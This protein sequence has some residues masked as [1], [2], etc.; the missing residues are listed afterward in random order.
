MS[1]SRISNP[2]AA[3]TVSRKSLGARS[4][5]GAQNMISSL[6]YKQVRAKS[7]ASKMSSF[8]RLNPLLPSKNAD[9]PKEKRLE[10]LISTFP[11]KLNPFLIE[12]SAN[13]LEYFDI[14][15]SLKA[16]VN[17]KKEFWKSWFEFKNKFI[18]DVENAKDDYESTRAPVKAIQTVRENF[19]KFSS[20]ISEVRNNQ[21]NKFK[22]YYA[23][24][25]KE[26]MESFNQIQKIIDVQLNRHS[27]L[28]LF[29]RD[30]QFIIIQLKTFHDQLP[31]EHDRFFAEPFDPQYTNVQ[32]SKNQIISMVL[33]PIKETISYLTMFMNPSSVID[34]ASKAIEKQEELFINIIGEPTVKA[35]DRY[36]KADSNSSQ[37]EINDF[38]EI[39]QELEEQQQNLT[40][41]LEAEIKKKEEKIEEIAKRTEEWEKEKKRLEIELKSLSTSDNSPENQAKRIKSLEKQI[42]EKEAELAKFDKS[43]MKKQYKEKEAVFEE[44][45]KEFKEIQTDIIYQRARIQAKVDNLDTEEQKEPYKHYAKL[46]KEVLSLENQLE[47][48]QIAT[49]GFRNFMK[50]FKQQNLKIQQIDNPQD[51]L[52]IEIEKNENKFQYID[53][54]IRD[55]KLLKDK[56]LQARSK[57][58]LSYAVEEFYSEQ[59]KKY[60]RT[61][62]RLKAMIKE[63]PNAEDTRPVFLAWA[64][65]LAKNADIAD[66]QCKIDSIIGGEE[67]ANTSQNIKDRVNQSMVSVSAREKALSHAI[68]CAQEGNVEKINKQT[69]KVQKE[70]EQLKSELSSYESMIKKIETKLKMNGEGCA[71]NDRI[72]AINAVLS[73]K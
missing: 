24:K 8:E 46:V 9:I 35:Q 72:A 48:L 54:L 36:G 57:M 61:I 65:A 45:R 7:K 51:R 22:K 11:S 67:G 62:R 39:V 68:K 15:K 43:K 17:D 38:R 59:G 64:E 5:S 19:N 63:D 32:P 2:R 56:L 34:E 70:T 73:H 58:A 66:L 25:F 41:E 3:S 1:K 42:E 30:L 47:V 27:D 33:A 53:D 71:I 21:S 49:N 18:T 10:N 12:D 29:I 55:D 16:K 40:E 52:A 23:N 60:N 4:A 20:E 69:H 13:Q 50:N 37:N 26:L 31:V 28:K 44:K 14:Y 6:T